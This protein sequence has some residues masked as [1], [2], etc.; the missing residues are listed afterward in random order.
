[1]GLVSFPNHLKAAAKAGVLVADP[2]GVN[3]EYQLVA[4]EL[5]TGMKESTL[6]GLGSDPMPQSNPKVSDHLVEKSKLAIPQDW[7]LK[8][9]IT[10]NELD[11][12]QT[13]QLAS[14]FSGVS[15]SYGKHVNKRVFTMLN[16]GDTSTYGLGYD[17]Q[18]FF[19]SDHTDK[20]AVYQ[21]DQD[22]EYALALDA[23]NF[24]TVFAAAENVKDDRGEPCGFN[25]NLLVAPP[26][27]RKAAHNI[28]GN[29]WLF[30]TANRDLN[31]WQQG[32][33]Y[34]ISPYLDSSAWHLL[35]SGENVKPLI[36]VWRVQPYLQEITFDPNQEKGGL[37]V[38]HYH[39]RY[40]VIY[41]D[42]RLAFQGNT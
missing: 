25:A 5:G 13:G 36:V 18:E 42:W 32:L 1:M 4:G 21:T 38:A 34:I 10:K 41:G 23:D 33:T 35:A 14:R 24:N 3:F 15:R 22:N 39:A 12:D 29:E 40:V 31:P 11:D 6:V 7:Y 26:A 37:F 17:G 2:N 28:A 19:D 8:V 30:G 27:L 20:G 9:K 16:G